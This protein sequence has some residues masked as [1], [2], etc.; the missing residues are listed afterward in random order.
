MADELE[1]P[2]D[3][4]NHQENLQMFVYCSILNRLVINIIVDPDK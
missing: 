4:L 3:D 1:N 2:G